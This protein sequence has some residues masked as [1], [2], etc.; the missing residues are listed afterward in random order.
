MIKVRLDI[1]RDGG[2]VGFHA[3]SHGDRV[4]CAAVSALIINTVNSIESL[5]DTDFNCEHE[6]ERFIT[7]RLKSEADAGARLLLEALMLGL[8]SIAEEHPGEITVTTE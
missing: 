3:D 2:I 7:F 5:T 6:N 4:V 8:T 1:G